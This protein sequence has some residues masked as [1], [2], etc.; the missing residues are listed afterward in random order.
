MGPMCGWYAKSAT[1]RSKPS[2]QRRQQP[3]PSARRPSKQPETRPNKESEI[4]CLRLNGRRPATPVM[5]HGRQPRSNGG[6][7]QPGKRYGASIP[8][9]AACLYSLRATRCSRT[10][11]LPTSCGDYAPIDDWPPRW[12][13]A[14]QTSA[15]QQPNLD[16]YALI[17][18]LSDW[19]KISVGGKISA[20]R[21][22]PAVRG[23]RPR[24]RAYWRGGR[25]CRF[26][27]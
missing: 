2:M 8:A 3:M 12:P 4:C 17:Q 18:S 13:P 16:Q 27:A 25:S 11:R 19:S 26:R 22:R 23:P 1:G 7:R 15:G 10:M 14:P 20:L 24:T 21:C 9:R 5:R 6:R